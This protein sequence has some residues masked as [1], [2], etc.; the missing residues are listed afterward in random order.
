MTAFSLKLH[1]SHEC[2]YDA[3]DQLG[4]GRTELACHT[5]SSVIDL[6]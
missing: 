5:R 6:D 2:Y 3:T 1:M 4:P